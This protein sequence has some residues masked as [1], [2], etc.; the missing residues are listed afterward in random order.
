MLAALT[1]PVTLI[2]RATS[3]SDVVFKDELDALAAARGGHVH[4][5]VGARADLA[6]DPLSPDA[7]RDLV[8]DLGERD[9][10]VCGPPG[11]IATASTALAAAGVARRRIHAE[12][13]E[14]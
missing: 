8:P 11:M 9:A 12:S 6:A 10:Y 1:G 5:V 2:Y 3:W 14:F 7:L 13:F 4:Y